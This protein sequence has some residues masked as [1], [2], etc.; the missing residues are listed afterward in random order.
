M[1]N[2]HFE[3]SEAKEEMGGMRDHAREEVEHK[4]GY[5]EESKSDAKTEQNNKAS[6]ID[7]ILANS[8]LQSYCAGTIIDDLS[9]HFMNFMQISNIKNRRIIF[10]II[11]QYIVNC[12]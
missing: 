2:V 5:P 9:D 10:T 12:I 7:H 1:S 11:K 6:L 4:K 3:P 8:N